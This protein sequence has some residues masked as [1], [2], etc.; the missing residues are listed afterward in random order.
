MSAPVIHPIDHCI[1]TVSSWPDV[2][3]RDGQ[4]D[5]TIFAVGPREIGRVHQCG[6]VDIRYPK[7][8]RNQ[9]IAEGR[10]NEYYPAPDS[11]VTTFYLTSTDGVK[12][13]ISLLRVSYL[14]HVS[15]LRRSSVGD[16]LTEA[17]DMKTELLELEPSDEL[18]MAICRTINCE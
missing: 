6:P 16:D 4:F 18:R 9:L 3:T 5:A 10:T 1:D 11:N 13:A 12:Q 17:I 8:L 2:T 15:S 14:Y 7:H